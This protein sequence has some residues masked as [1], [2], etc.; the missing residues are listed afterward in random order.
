MFY[1]NDLPVG[2]VFS[3]S[4]HRRVELE[5]GDTDGQ[6]IVVESGLAVGEQVSLLYPE[7]ANREPR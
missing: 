1:E 5:L 3:E 6:H 2:F 4:A 7:G